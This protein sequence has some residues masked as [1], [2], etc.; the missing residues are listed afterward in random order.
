MSK[1]AGQVEHRL[2]TIR[3][4]RHVETG[5]LLAISDEMKGL[6]VHARSEK[7]LWERIPIAIR[8]IL[9]ADGVAA[10]RHQWHAANRA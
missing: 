3:T 2:I 7:D 6:Y 10:F 4:L 9:E 1:F 8:A 5:L